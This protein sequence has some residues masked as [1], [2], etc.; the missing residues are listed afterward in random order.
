M[1][2]QEV[3]G[4][5]KHTAAF[6]R[7]Y[8]E[9]RVPHA[10][11]VLAPEGAGGLPF[12]MAMAQ[13]LECENPGEDVCG[14]CPSCL[15]AAKMIHPDIHYTFPVIKKDGQKDP[16]ISDEWIGPFR[17]AYLK[18]PYQ[19]TND[20]LQ[21]FGGEKKSGNIT[22]KECQQIIH[23]LN[24]KTFEGRAKVQIIWRPELLGKS[25]NI[26]LKLIEEPPPDTYLILV[27]EDEEQIL[28]TILSRCQITR[29]SALADD[30]VIAGLM[31]FNP[32]LSEQDA[33]RIAYQADGN[34]N[35]AMKGVVAQDNA[36]A[37][38]LS[39]WLQAA[40]KGQLDELLNWIDQ[41]SQWVRE[42]Q[43]QF[44]LYA[45]RYFR[46]ILQVA[47]QSVYRPR[48]EERQ[49]QGVQWLAN[50][51][52]WESVQHIVALLERQHYYVVRNTH[53]KIQLL[54]ASLEL[55]ALLQNKQPVPASQ[56][57]I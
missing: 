4:Q 17:E 9:G 10:Q 47:I 28:G 19:N 44:F 21:S 54:H 5:S 12:A 36:F 38:H 24:L 27:A 48:V 40:Y 18:N 22:V 8:R 2:L 29:M 35:A 39:T 34:L 37:D 11:L 31:Q 13:Y 49:L 42:E 53:T 56:A 50:R 43:K 7:A 55:M 1:R 15:K 6:V 3:I 46:E 51:L 16:P 23:K 30:A 33:T 52:T 57:S 32:D 41:F 26:L 20:W 45:E 25:G 14:Q